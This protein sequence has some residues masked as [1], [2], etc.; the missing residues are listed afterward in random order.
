MR[1]TRSPADQSI[2][3]R[4]RERRMVLGLSQRQFGEMIGLTTQQV[5]R[6]E[7]GF[8]SISAS[9][10][11][12]IA[13]NLG[14]PLEYFF[15]GLEQNESQLPLRQSRLLDVMRSFGEM[16][17]EKHQMVISQIVRSLAGA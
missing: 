17:N 9:R 5:Q 16:Q 15:E 6:Y 4:I 7:L 11:Y 13:H 10:L 12:E 8:N 3:L 1:K 2:G 14:T